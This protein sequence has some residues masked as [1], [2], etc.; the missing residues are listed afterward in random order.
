MLASALTNTTFM[1]LDRPNPIGGTHAFGPVLDEE[2]AS[3]VGRRAIA[4]AHGMTA[5]ELARMFVGE[6][7]IR[8][9][10]NGSE[11][12]LE[13]VRM[14]GWR[15]EMRWED[16]GLPWVMP[17]PSKHHYLCVALLEGEGGWMHADG[18]G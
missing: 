10:T 12:E 18:Y 5:G 17:S 3:Y 11:L 4:Q 8:E 14:K 15:R 1:V 9:A 7:W 13:V 2:F 16:T 6:G